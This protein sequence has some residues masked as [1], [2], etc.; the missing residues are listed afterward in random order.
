MA[1]LKRALFLGDFTSA[2]DRKWQQE[3]NI[4]H[5][6]TVAR[7]LNIKVDCKH[8]VIDVL[9][10]PSDNL[11]IYFEQMNDFIEQ[12]LKKGNVLVHC[13]AG[14]SRSASAVIAYIMKKNK[15]SFNKTRN[16]VMSKRSVI[17]PNDGFVK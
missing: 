15:W 16:F 10:D 5:V 11:L 14:V 3:N 2:L 7:G 6:L 13:A 4:C 12:G 9:D 8:L 1:L 17:Y